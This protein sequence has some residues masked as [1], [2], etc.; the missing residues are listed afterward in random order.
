[1]KIINL[2]IYI[3]N[4]N[5][6]IQFNS[7]HALLAEHPLRAHGEAA[8]RRGGIDQ[9]AGIVPGDLSFHGCNEYVVQ[10]VVVDRVEAIYLK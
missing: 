9:E 4:K 6:N 7:E 1:M 8:V 2:I 5:I 3:I 10:D